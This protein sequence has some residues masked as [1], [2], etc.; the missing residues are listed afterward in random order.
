M[1]NT[2]RIGHRERKREVEISL[3]RSYFSPGMRVLEF[4]AGSGWQA[5]LLGQFGCR[6]EAIDVT[7]T[8]ERYA[9]VLIYDGRTIPYPDGSFDAVFS[10]NTLEHVTDLDKSL[11]EIRRVLRPSGLAVFILPSAAW[12]FWTSITAYPYLLKRLMRILHVLQDEG[13]LQ[14]RESSVEQPRYSTTTRLLRAIAS[15]FLPHGEQMSAFHELYYYRRGPWIREFRRNGFEVT[16]VFASHL[17]YTGAELLPGLT[18]RFRRMLAL[19]LG[20]ATNV[21]ILGRP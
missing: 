21:Y 3:V 15:P 19:F 5:K 16:R 7:G 4:G 2:P 11:G 13:G 1:N 12:R 20:S 10:S 6:V 14:A 9:P 8:A 17:F 18:Y